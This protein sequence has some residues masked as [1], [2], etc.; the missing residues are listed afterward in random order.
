MDGF[1]VHLG[2]Q[3]WYF[4]TAPVCKGTQGARDDASV[5]DLSTRKG[6]VATMEMGK[7]REDRFTQVA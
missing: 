1:W 7:M 3:S 4:L 6:G 5:L 2:K